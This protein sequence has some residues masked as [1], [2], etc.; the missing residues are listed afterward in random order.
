MGVYKSSLNMKQLVYIHASFDIIL[1]NA[2][3]RAIYATVGR[4]PV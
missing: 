1:Y 3:M 4:I 2:N